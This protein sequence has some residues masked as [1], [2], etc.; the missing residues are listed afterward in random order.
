M[1]DDY[2]TPPDARRFGLRPRARRPTQGGNTSGDLGHRGSHT[3]ACSGGESVFRIGVFPF[4]V[5]LGACILEVSLQAAGLA[6]GGIGGGG[7]L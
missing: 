7:S 5:R 3:C 6:Y 2:K 1:Y 4:F